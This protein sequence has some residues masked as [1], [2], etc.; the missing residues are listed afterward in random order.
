MTFLRHQ[1]CS[2]TVKA[3]YSKLSSQGGNTIPISRFVYT[4]LTDSIKVT[5]TRDQTKGL[6]TWTV[7]GATAWAGQT[8]GK[9]GRKHLLHMATLFNN[10]T[11]MHC[12]CFVAWLY[13]MVLCTHMDVWTNLGTFSSSVLLL[14]LHNHPLLPQLVPVLS[15]NI[16]VHF[17]AISLKPPSCTAGH[18][19]GSSFEFDSNLLYG[20]PTAPPV[21][22]SLSHVLIHF[23]CPSVS[24]V[25]V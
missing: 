22:T 19:L 4:W 2:K 1:C 23:E 18:Y 14:E 5:C 12:L 21:G 7:S 20:Y 17:E 8:I 13:K 6:F 25:P 9:P 24:L 15:K 10:L 3:W 16:L 11:F